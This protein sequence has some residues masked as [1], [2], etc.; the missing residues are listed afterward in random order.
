[1]ACSGRWACSP[2]PHPGRPN[3]RGGSAVPR[4]GSGASVSAC[5]RSGRSLLPSSSPVDL[6]RSAAVG[7]CMVDLIREPCRF[8]G[9]KR[10][11]GTP[12]RRTRTDRT[13]R[14][15]SSD[16]VRVSWGSGPARQPQP[17]HWRGPCPTR[18]RTHWP[19]Q[20]GPLPRGCCLVQGRLLTAY[21][22]SY[23]AERLLR[24]ALHRN[25]LETEH[26]P[27]LFSQHPHAARP[28]SRV[29]RN[30]SLISLRTPRHGATS[31][32]PCTCAFVRTRTC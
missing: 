26:G 5:G 20:R 28:L 8:P 7:L 17:P 12:G 18:P 11:T 13:G 4:S 14:V 25:R 3:G 29:H 30:A 23:K 16:G 2:P 21:R 27:D 31:T 24:H 19:G 1:M 10:A 15:L 32:P 22:V 6:C 9:S